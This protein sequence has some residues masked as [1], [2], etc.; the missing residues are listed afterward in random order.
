MEITTDRFRENVSETLSDQPYVKAIK[1][2]TALFRQGRETCF[3]G[4]FQ[5]ETE[6]QL[7]R[8]IKEGAVARLDRLLETLEAS[9]TSR[10]G[11]VHWAWDAR[12][13]NETIL[14]L[15]KNRGV[16]LIVKSKSM[17]TEEIGLNDYLAEQGL[18]VVETDFGE[19]I[20]QLAHETPSHLTTPAMHK[21]KEEVSRLLAEKLGIPAYE[22]VDDMVGEVRPRLR[23]IF[24]KADMGITGVN[25]A[26]AE[27]GTLVQ[28]TNE[29]N[30]RMVSTLPSMLVAIMGIEK[31]IPTLK[32][33]P[34]FVRLLPRSNAGQWITTYVNFISP[35]D[36]RKR[37]T[38]PGEFHLVILDNGRS[39]ILAD[40]EMRE[41]LYCIRCSACQNYCP[42][43]QSLGGKAYGWIYGGP[44]GSMLTPL[45]LGIEK[46]HDLPFASTLCGACR[47]VCSV[48][49]DIPRI[50]LKL[51][52]QWSEG[53][54]DGR[55]PWTERAAFSL[56]RATF[57]R[58]FSY[59]FLTMA[60]LPFLRTSWGRWIISKLPVGSGWAKSRELPL[61]AQRSFKDRWKTMGPRLSRRG[62]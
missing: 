37:W 35:D 12:E 32:D 4:Y 62:K 50:L 57:S 31:V 10:G 54:G 24:L 47:D 9:I 41:A 36:S 48:K 53:R 30:G 49:I 33:L 28:V 18:E 34:V 7:A 58:L 14:K 3:E 45:F 46:A 38:R 6:R 11:T 29:G 52:S 16:K 5:V 60:F 2:G 55:P 44:I 42:V 26:V 17:V 40:P 13:A 15:A 19:Y 39:R 1:K 59:R 8:S 56:W 27:T 20:V 43:Y 51:R 23:R 21:S 61:P 22:T 25:F